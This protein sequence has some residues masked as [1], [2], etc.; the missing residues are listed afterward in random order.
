MHVLLC[1]NWH[2]FVCICRMSVRG[3]SLGWDGLMT[4]C[5]KRHVAPYIRVE[6]VFSIRIDG[7]IVT[8]GRCTCGQVVFNRAPWITASLEG[9]P[10]E[11]SSLVGSHS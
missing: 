10:H 5:L 2:G 11:A 8:L 4:K 6:I 1:Q 3:H 7:G 9:D